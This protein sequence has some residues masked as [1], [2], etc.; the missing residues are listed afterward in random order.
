MCE[1]FA[2]GESCFAECQINPTDTITELN[3]DKSSQAIV[4][5]VVED[6]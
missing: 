6:A 2:M 1:Y 3:L 5:V 4:E